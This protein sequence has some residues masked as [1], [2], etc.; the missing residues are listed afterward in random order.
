MK[1]RLK[2]FSVIA[3]IIALL[4]FAAPVTA[5]AGEGKGSGKQGSGDTVTE[6][7]DDDGFA[8]SPDRFGDDDN[9]HPSG[10][11]RSTEGGNSGNQGN[12]TSAPDEDGHG[13]ERDFEGTDKPGGP[14]GVDKEDQDGN[15]GCGNDDDFEDDNEGWCGPKP[16]EEE[17]EVGGNVD[18]V[19]D[20][21]E[22]MAGIQP[23]DKDDETDDEVEGDV[24]TKPCEDDAAMGSGEVCGDDLLTDEAAQPAGA[25]V[26]L[27]TQLTQGSDTPDVAAAAAERSETEGG[28]LPF[29]GSTL[30]AFVLLGLG[31]AASGAVLLKARRSN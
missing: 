8:N 20:K 21:D 25:D 19:C 15:N 11:D 2:L 4:L 14:G 6:D 23:C 3:V 30:I 5:T 28:V 12:S 31:L 24:I 13:P 7:N 10:K 1:G 29:T 18:E 17:T 9:R 16:K 27:G 26:V 22:T